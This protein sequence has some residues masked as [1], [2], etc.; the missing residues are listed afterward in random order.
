MEMEAF[1][2]DLDHNIGLKTSLAKPDQIT[3]GD[4]TFCFVSE[5]FKRLKK[6]KKT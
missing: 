6:K 2:Y 3:K 5:W 4:E 1:V